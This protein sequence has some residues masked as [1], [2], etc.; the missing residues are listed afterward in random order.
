MI[1]LYSLAGYLLS[2]FKSFRPI[3][4]MPVKITYLDVIREAIRST[5]V[6][7][8][9]LIVYFAS[10]D[11]LNYLVAK[12]VWRRIEKIRV[13]LFSAIDQAEKNLQNTDD[14]LA[15][16][17]ALNAE[18]RRLVEEARAKGLWKEDV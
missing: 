2:F 18:T 5:F 17:K 10:V 9:V 3:E 7:G 1:P 14:V 12:Y 8:G 16:S 13:E 11:T 6:I 4:I 15:Q